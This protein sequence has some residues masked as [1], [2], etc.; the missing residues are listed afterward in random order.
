[1]KTLKKRNPAAGKPDSGTSRRAA[2]AASAKALRDGSGAWS[3]G[4]WSETHAALVGRIVGAMPQVEE[5]MADLTARLLGD[6][7]AAGRAVFRGL[8]GDEQRLR[9][10][11]ALLEQ[12]TANVAKGGDYDAAIACYA[13]ERRRWRAYVHGLWYTHENG[14]TFLAA[15]GGAEAASFLVAR[16]VKTA[17]LDMELARL[18]DLNA[19]L[20]RLVRP[21]V[22]IR[23]PP[24]PR[25]DGPRRTRRAPP[26]AG[27]AKR[28]AP[29]RE[30]GQRRKP[31]A[32]PPPA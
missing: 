6:Q 11:R 25:P 2:P 4:L 26:E 3:A 18:N 5:L 7:G 8:A 9:V 17:E 13:A 29:K 10:L 12:G 24:A 16:E 30:A 31:K 14:R 22:T 23:T 21:E 27:R 19:A 1:M 15:P 32:T 28:P 20:L